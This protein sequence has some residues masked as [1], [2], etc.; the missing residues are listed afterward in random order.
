MILNLADGSKT[1]LPDVRSYRLPR[2]NGTWMI[3]TAAPDSARAPG[4]TASRNPGAPGSG[5]AGGRGAGLGGRGG[6][7]AARAAPTARPSCSATSTRAPR[8]GFPT[9]SCMRSTTARRCWPTPSRRATR[10]KDGVYI[11]TMATGATKTVLSGRGNY[12]DFAFDR[13]QTAVRLHDRPRRVRQAGQRAACIYVGVREDGYRC[14]R[15][16]RR[17]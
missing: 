7:P 3:Y 1:S 9:C 13:T 5:A 17:R 10:T 8:S 11:R 15:G 12:R 4:D 14:A 2:D 6:A 16:R